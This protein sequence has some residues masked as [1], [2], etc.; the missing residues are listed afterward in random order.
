MANGFQKN[1][2]ST[3]AKENQIR[4][5][6]ESLSEKGL[7]TF[8]LTLNEIQMCTKLKKHYEQGQAKGRNLRSVKIKAECSVAIFQDVVRL[9]KSQAPNSTLDTISLEF[10]I[11]LVCVLDFLGHM[12]LCKLLVK[13]LLHMDKQ[14][15]TTRQK[16]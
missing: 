1:S 6:F 16:L 15:S 11:D 10:W 9:V 4:V 7:N 3:T 13:K 2:N 8:Y 5:T 12:S 14:D